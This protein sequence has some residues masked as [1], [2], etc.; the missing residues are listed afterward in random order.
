MN[1]N[2]HQ[3]DIFDLLP[4]LIDLKGKRI[5]V[6][7]GGNAMVD[8]SLQ[9]KVVDDIVF[10][11]LIGVKVVVV[12]GGGPA[13]SEH[14]RRVGLKPE[15]I[16]G[17]RRTDNDALEIVE[18]VLC[19]KVNNQ[20]V[21]LINSHGAK[22]IGLSGKDGNLIRARK[23]IREVINDGNFDPVDMGC[24]G[25]VE[26]ID[27]S[28]IEQF[29]K[30]GILPVIAPIGVGAD[31]EDYNINADVLAS[32]VA[33]S[34]EADTIIYLTDVDGLMLDQDEPSSLIRFIDA[35]TAK[36]MINR[37]ITGGMIPKVASC[38]KALENG[39]RSGM[40]VNGTK[41]HTML[42]SLV[43]PGEVGTMI[44]AGL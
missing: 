9:K 14:M 21:K 4:A 13:I 16:H 3:L 42:S 25:E 7:Y 34:I 17:Q 38:I 18:M 12:H 32:H 35:P 41:D 43:F 11:D 39:V 6:K 36:S 29:F 28:I 5:V 33:S 37:E 10:L 20:I 31:F 19:G 15:F 2:D 24:V 23:L 26:R 44:R 40:I 1:N 30:I 8:E 27:S 22:A